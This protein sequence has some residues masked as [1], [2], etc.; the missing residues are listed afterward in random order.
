MMSLL[1]PVMMLRTVSGAVIYSESPRL[2]QQRALRNVRLVPLQV[3]P[4]PMLRCGELMRVFRTPR[5]VVSGV[6][7]TPNS[8]RVPLC[9][10][11]Q[12]PLFVPSGPLVVTVV[13]RSMQFVVLVRVMFVVMYLCLAPPLSTKEWQWLSRV[14]SLLSRL[15][16]HPP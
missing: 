7:L 14:L 5:L 12:I 9:A 10:P 3:G 1:P 16:A 6:A 4:R 8:A 2:L 11:M 15:S 13:L